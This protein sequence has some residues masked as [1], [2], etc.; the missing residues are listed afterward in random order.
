MSLQ[1]IVNVQITK[2]TAALTRVG[3]GTPL[4]LVHHDAV[5][6][7]AKVYTDLKGMTDDGFLT[8]DLAYKAATAIF[9]QNPKV[10]QIVVGKRTRQSTR[11]IRATPKAP[12]L[13]TT[14][15]RLTINGVNFDYTTDAT[16]TAAE[17]TLALTTSID[18]GSV[19]VNA[20]DNTTDL[21]VQR[22]ASPGGAAEAGEPFTLEYD[23]AL[24][25]VIDETPDPGLAADIADVRDVNDDW[26]GVTGDWFGQA[27]A[28]VVSAAIEP[29]QRIHGWASQDTDVLDG[30]SS[31]DAFSDLKAAAYER[32]FGMWHTKP[33][34]FPAAAWIGVM[35]PFDPG[36]ATWKFKT[37]SGITF[38][39]FT[40]AELTALVAKNANHYVSVSGLNMTAE[41]VAHQGEFIDTVRGL[42]FVAQRIAEDVFRHLKVN[43]K[44][45]YTDAGAASVQSI[46]DGVLQSATVPGGGSGQIF[47]DDPAPVVTVPAVADVDANTRATRTLPDVNFTATLSGAV[48]KVEVSGTV[49]V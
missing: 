2:A 19:N 34:Q 17:I 28:T 33:H 43:P 8:T 23:K 15:Y 42:D 44:I 6:D 27:E 35:F 4:L 25:T 36:A 10:G 1:T 11:I 46:V 7:V 47:T 37:L 39:A 30:G 31:T 12:L 16:P 3:F 38:D 5:S 32:S 13:P 14:L 41:G 26:Y 9:S 48:H 21:T 22:A 49:T 20:V 18:G 45:P 40:G 29:L 24:W